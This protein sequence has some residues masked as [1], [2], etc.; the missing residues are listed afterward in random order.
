MPDTTPAEAPPSLASLMGGLIEDTQQLIRQEVALA[1]RELQDEWT[2][3][4]EGGTLLGSSLALF[5]LVGVLFSFTLVEVLHHFLMPNHLWACFAIV[6][7]VLGGAAAILYF[8]GKAKLDQVQLIPPQS[9]ASLR[10][11]VQAVASAVGA[12]PTNGNLVGQR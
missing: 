3:T 11:D 8:S 10:Q 6:T 7:A 2:K 1:R 5:G 9:A 4:K 12:A